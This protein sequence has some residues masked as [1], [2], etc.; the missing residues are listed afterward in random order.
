MSQIKESLQVEYL[1]DAVAQKTI[2]RLTFMK[3]TF[4]KMLDLGCHSGNFEK[5]LLKE[6]EDTK[7]V[8]DKFNE[9]L[10]IDGS[11]GM[12]HRFDDCDDAIDADYNGKLN[13]KKLLCDEEELDHEELR[14]MNDSFDAVISNLSI[15]WI[16]N[17]PLTLA[18]INNLLKPDGLFLASMICED[19][20]FELR[21][22]LQL[23]EI[24]RKGGV[25][26]GRI[27]PMIKV[28]DMTNLLKMAK[29]NMVTIDVEEI[30]VQYPNVFT[31][32]EDLQL[33]GENNA[34]KLPLEMLSKDV[35]ISTEA[36]YK[37]L[38][39]V[40]DEEVGCVLPLTFRI[41]FIV[42]W[43]ESKNQ[44]KPLERGTGDVNLKEALGM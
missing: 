9:I 30:V 16:N 17:L 3:R 28:D 27:S 38:H 7:L 1:R 19:S 11:E 44:P 35:L 6:D 5:A 2:E 23:A 8:R 25:S 43:K 42:G 10:M 4:P 32:M 39:G 31:I 40:N 41:M 24:E 29:F 18:K 15:H 34:N 12:L 14:K 21:T 20:I 33:M 13:V 36:I 26:M 22:S 37:K